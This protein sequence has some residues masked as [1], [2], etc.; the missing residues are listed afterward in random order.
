ML[1]TSATS[2]RH[3]STPNSYN[4]KAKCEPQSLIQVVNLF[5]IKVNVQQSLVLKGYFTRKFNVMLKG[6]VTRKFNVMKEHLF[7]KN[8]IFQLGYLI[9]HINFCCNASNVSS[10]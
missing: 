7:Y 3:I 8:Y 5:L 6:Y 2:N 9:K 10:V 1:E 4:W